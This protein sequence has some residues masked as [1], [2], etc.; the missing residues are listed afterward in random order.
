MARIRRNAEIGSRDARLRLKAR[1]EPYWQVIERGLSLGYRKSAEGGA[2]VVRRYDAARRRHVEGRVATADDNR[3][4]DGIEV[5]NHGQAQRKVLSESHERALKASGK[6]YT[7]AEA[8]ADYVEQRA[9]DAETTL[10]AYLLPR[11]GERRV[12]ELTTDDFKAWKVWAFKRPMQRK[13]K[14]RPAGKKRNFKKPRQRKP[15]PAAKLVDKEEE[16]RKRKS[17]I[18]RVINSVKACLNYAHEEGKVANAE[19]WSKLRKYPGADSARIRW[20]TLE[21]ATRLQNAA[22]PDLRPLILSAMLTGCRKGELLRLKARDF[23]SESKT[24]LILKSKS[25]RTA[26][27]KH[28]RV[29]LNADGVALFETLTAGK[30]GDE[31]LFKCADG[32][33][34]Y[35]MKLTRTLNAAYA[36]AKVAPVRFHELRHTYASHLA[37][38]GEP[39]LNIAA[40]LGHKDTRMVEKHYAHLA[41]SHLHTTVGKL[42]SF[43][44]LP[45]SNVQKLKP[46]KRARK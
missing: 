39:L 22:G 4:A 46:K 31:L 12:A 19:A 42:P 36:A 15:K 18:N 23:E 28:R 32:S 40:L 10:N 37:Q 13:S 8:I 25:K 1:A 27:A 16:I 7:V 21:E 3:E 5:L 45:T 14:T 2:W 41:P 26:T 9:S 20:L 29:Y 35:P 38:L 34:W 6:L 24:L 43:G 30:T 44:T 17:T 33:D 11:F